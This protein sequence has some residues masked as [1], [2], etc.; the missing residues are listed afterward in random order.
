[1]IQ[2]PLES[3]SFDSFVTGAGDEMGSEMSALRISKT[4]RLLPADSGA[5]RILYKR[6]TTLL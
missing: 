6:A 1:M 3:I 5:C 2:L 4:L